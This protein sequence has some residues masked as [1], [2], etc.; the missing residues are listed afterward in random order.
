MGIIDEIFGQNTTT[1]YLSRN[2]ISSL[3]TNIYN[4]FNIEEQYELPEYQFKSNFIDDFILKTSATNFKYVQFDS[5]LELLSKYSI[6]VADD[7]KPDEIKSSL[8][9][10]FTIEQSKNISHIKV[11]LT[12]NKESKEASESNG[13]GKLSTNVLGE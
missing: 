8:G 3:S 12:D 2:Q 13:S 9:K 7:L 1:V 4:L 10:I 11:D 5:A 6:S